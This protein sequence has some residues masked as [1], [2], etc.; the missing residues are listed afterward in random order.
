MARPSSRVTALAFAALA[1]AAALALAACGEEEGP[2]AD[3]EIRIETARFFPSTLDIPAG[4]NVRWVNVLSRAPENLRTVTSGS[5]PPD[6]SDGA[7][8]D[9]TLQGYPPGTGRGETVTRRFDEPGVY[10][11]FTRI[12]AGS[13]YAGSITVF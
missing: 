5:L 10:P 12:P 11:Y 9:D 13:E 7:A 6:A 4:S 8:F 2:G 1:F 3:Y